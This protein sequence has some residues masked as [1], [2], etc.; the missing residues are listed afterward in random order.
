MIAGR[1]LR[2]V[3][4]E[5]L[6][7]SLSSGYSVLWFLLCR[8]RFKVAGRVVLK[9]SFRFLGKSRIALGSLT[10]G[11]RIWIEAVTAYGSQRFFPRLL[12]GRNLRM[13]DDVRIGCT[14]RVRI[15][16]DV[17]LGSHILITDHDHG[18]YSGD[19]EA[20]SSPAEP[21]ARR[22]LTSTGRVVIEDRVHIGSY[23][24]VCKN[25]RIGRG[26]VVAAHSVVTGDIPPNS[27]AAGVPARVI[28]TWN[29]SEG[30]WY[31]AG[32]AAHG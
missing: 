30:R 18:I 29:S 8:K 4:A 20:H 17:L 19:A 16:N 9:G 7:R 5:G 6:W 22:A 1:V 26:S 11:E 21:P 2:Y 15:G 25:V 32:R 31:S 27:I 23:V 3:W 24:T 10:A 12:L 28:S 14:H 13:T